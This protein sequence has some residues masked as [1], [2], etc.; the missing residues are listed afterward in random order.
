MGSAATSWA[1]RS[2]R[3]RYF[4]APDGDT[5]AQSMSSSGG[6]ANTTVRRT[7]STPYC[8]S[9]A[10]RST[11]LPSD[12]LMARPWLMTWPWFISA[13][14][15]STASTMPMS[16]STF[17]KKRLYSRCRIACSTPPTYCATGIHS[18]TAAGSNGP[19]S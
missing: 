16:C 10:P 12:L 13:A 17:M 4:T 7:A 14:N 18:R 19:S 9:C 11:P 5:S 3:A 1:T 8:D 2:A 15:G 6:P